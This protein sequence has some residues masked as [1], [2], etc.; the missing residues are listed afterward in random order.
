M[1]II[2]DMK[3]KTMVKHFNF[4]YQN[5]LSRLAVELLAAKRLLKAE[6]SK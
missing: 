4:I 6:S 1:Q 2:T 5:A 3:K